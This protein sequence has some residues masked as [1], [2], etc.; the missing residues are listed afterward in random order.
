MSCHCCHAS[1]TV[2]V[3]AVTTGNAPVEIV[4]PEEPMTTQYHPSQTL[5]ELQDSIR[6]LRVSSTATKEPVDDLKT[7]PMGCAFNSSHGMIT[8]INTLVNAGFTIDAFPKVYTE[9]S[10]NESFINY[11]LFE[12]DCDISD[13][14]P[15]ERFRV[16]HHILDLIMGPNALHVDT[17]FHKVALNA[18]KRLGECEDS[19]YRIFFIRVVSMC[20]DRLMHAEKSK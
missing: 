9:E 13:P 4:K 17:D 5:N 15:V 11:C 2:S 16:Y 8:Y 7:L 20:M 18:I 19:M 6:E 10:G 14:D 1:V 3:P 12:W